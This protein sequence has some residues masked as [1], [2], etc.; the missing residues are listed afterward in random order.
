MLYPSFFTQKKYIN[1]LKTGVGFF[2][3]GGGGGGGVDLS[4]LIK[5]V[6]MTYGDW[7]YGTF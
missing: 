4:S 1:F 6:H 7:T 3:G 2:G 5:I